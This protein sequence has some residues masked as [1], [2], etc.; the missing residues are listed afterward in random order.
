MGI[1]FYLLAEAAVAEAAAAA[2]PAE[3]GFGL[4]FDLLETN[5][6]NIAIVVGVLIYF[7]R[8][9]L[10]QLLQD[11]RAKIEADLQAAEARAKE[12]DAALAA[13]N[14]KLEQ[15]QAEV[16]R[17][18]QEAETN[19]RN[20]KEKI[21]ADSTAEVERIK[22]A[23]VRDLDTERER[24]IAEIKAQVTRLALEQVEAQLPQKLSAA[25]TQE[26]LV[27]RALAQIGG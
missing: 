13:A 19:A 25:S 9:F 14:R 15:A 10:G 12:A 2:E 16:E 8:G 1:Q 22:A 23:A 21:L 6:I 5:V 24:A 17:L 11:R 7:G 3:H 20:V 26:Q 4:N 18:R 27:D